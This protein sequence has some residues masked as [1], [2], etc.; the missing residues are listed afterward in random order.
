MKITLRS[1]DIGLYILKTTYRPPRNGDT[2]E[3][4][5]LLLL[6][7]ENRNA[8]CRSVCAVNC[9]RVNRRRKHGLYFCSSVYVLQPAGA[10]A[11]LTE[12]AAIKWLCELSPDIRFHIPE[13]AVTSQFHKRRVARESGIAHHALYRISENGKLRRIYADKLADTAALDRFC[14]HHRRQ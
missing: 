12:Q 11:G 7:S 9:I 8:E 2:S 1:D 10:A 5:N 14:A 3:S 13:F 6:D 4:I